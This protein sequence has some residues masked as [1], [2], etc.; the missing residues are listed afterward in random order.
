MYIISDCG[1]IQY[2]SSGLAPRIFPST[3]RLTCYSHTNG[4]SSIY[5]YIHIIMCVYMSIIISKHNYTAIYH[6]SHD[7]IPTSA[8]Y[9]Y[10]LHVNLIFL[11]Q[12]IMGFMVNSLANILNEVMLLIY[13]NFYVR[14][15]GIY[16]FWA[17]WR[18]SFPEYSNLFRGILHALT[19]GSG[20]VILTHEGILRLSRPIDYAKIQVHGWAVSASIVYGCVQWRT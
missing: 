15:K 7:W 5:C 16:S 8:T 20:N 10:M 11:C 2:K 6:R 4:M 1:H 17:E 18:T 19:H 3:N 14:C 9:Q 13:G 12:G